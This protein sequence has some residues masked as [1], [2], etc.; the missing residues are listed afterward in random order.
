M[1]LI[2]FF[3]VAYVYAVNTQIILSDCIRIS[4]NMSISHLTLEV[5]QLAQYVFVDNVRNNKIALDIHGLG[6]SKDLFCFCLDLF[7]KGIVLVASNGNGSRRVD[8]DTLSPE[9]F[10]SICRKMRLAGIK[11]ILEMTPIDT[12]LTPEESKTILHHSI[13]KIQYMPENLL[14]KEYMFTIKLQD[15]LCTVRFDLLPV[16]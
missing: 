12:P 1:V 4:K 14:V 15:M 8:I 3:F 10:E 7:C 16:N 6:D 5:E 9:Q 2:L 13:L 11:C